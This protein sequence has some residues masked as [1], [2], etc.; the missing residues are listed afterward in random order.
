MN[1]T[2]QIRI[3]FVILICLSLN[4]GCGNSAQKPLSVDPSPHTHKAPQK[5]YQTPVP[6]PPVLTTNDIESEAVSIEGVSKATAIV[7]EQEIY[8]GIE[9]KPDIPKKLAPS[10]EREVMNEVKS[11]NS[12]YKV[13]VT[14]DTDTVRL[15][16]TVAN[17]IAKGHTLSSFKDEINTIAA[18]MQAKNR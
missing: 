5:I 2:K 18:K 11:M 15:I 7:S 4:A 16:K 14:S 9:L 12:Q 1:F 10:R 3:I 17:G 13:M 6:T 8:V